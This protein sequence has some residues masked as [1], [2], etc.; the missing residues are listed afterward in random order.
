MH[1]SQHISEESVIAREHEVQI[2]MIDLLKRAIETDKP[3]A[4]QIAILDQLISY[5][6]VH[7]M[8]EQL[9]MRQH[10]YEGYDAH[11]AEH[12]AIMSQLN[13]LKEQTQATGIDA[14]NPALM[15][16]RGLLLSHIATQDRDLSV[17][18]A[19]QQG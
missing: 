12:D 1:K 7:F 13:S 16:L 8:S 9:I 3:E 2:S 11:D 17:F 15:G 10:S 18:L 19:R 5:T 6:D 4:E 14:T